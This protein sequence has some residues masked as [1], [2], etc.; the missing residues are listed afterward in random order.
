MPSILFL[1][2]NFYNINNFTE[3]KKIYK[4]LN[5]HGSVFEWY[6]NKQIA[7]IL[8]QENN[9]ASA[10]SLLSRSYDKLN[11]RGIYEGFD[12]AEFLKTMNSLNRQL[13]ITLLF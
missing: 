8:I 13:N 9:K 3:A 1:A 7:R 5:I 10:L 12:Y 6:S 2:E 4:N 11:H